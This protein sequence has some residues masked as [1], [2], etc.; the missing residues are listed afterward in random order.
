MRNAI[1][2]LSKQPLILIFLVALLVRLPGIGSRPFWYD[3]AFSVLFSSQGPSAMAYGTLTQEAGVAADIHPLGYYTLLWLWGKAF[4]ASPI[5][6]RSL[7]LL[8]GLGIVGLGYLLASRLFGRKVAV[9]SAWMLAFAPFQVHYAQEARMYALLALI[10]LAATLTYWHCLQDRGYWSWI[11]FAVLAAAAMYV[12]NLAALFLFCLALTPLLLRRWRDLGKTALS[13]LAAV[14]LYLP[15]LVQLPSQLARVNWA[16]WIPRPEL[17]ELV[18]TLLVFT[19]G[20]PLPDWGLS[21]A[22]FLAILIV[23]TGLW[24]TLR[25]LRP[26]KPAGRRAAWI[27]GLSGGP[28]VLMF[29]I[30]QIQPV[31][32]DRAMLP[33]GVM[34]MIWLAWTIEE[35]SLPAIARRGVLVATGFAFVLGLG[36]FYIYRGFPYAPFDAV[37]QSL[38][39]GLSTNE[40]VLHS[41]KITVIPA[42][43]D[44]PTL[45]HEYLADPPGSGSDTLAIATQEVL[46]LFAHADVEQ[47]VGDAAGVW[48]I[49]FPRE[50]DDYS[51]QGVEEHPALTWLQ[52]E[53]DLDEVTSYGDL[54]VYHFLR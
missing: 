35:S 24:T 16:Y 31:Y 5:A 40:V 20:L 9:L 33:A 26:A 22:L 45:D 23:A 11:L 18:R 34:F 39:E 54:D 32:L 21:I 2:K 10:L 25:A 17:I 53:F 8:L 46:G 6:I 30:S 51:R 37:N 47:A 43:Y 27:L 15:W 52:A 48:F 13:A 3:E 1:S 41:N 29:L 50:I 49:I 28:V 14:V 12:H 19:T 36:S 4:G 38:H 7:S 42:V 44:D